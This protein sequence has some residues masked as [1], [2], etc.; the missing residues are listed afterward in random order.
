MAHAQS[1]SHADEHAAWEAAT[2]KPEAPKPTPA[3]IAAAGV[4]LTRREALALLGAAGA[5]TLAGCPTNSNTDTGEN[6]AGQT[7]V[8]RPAE[9]EGPYFVDERLNRADIRVDPADGSIQDGVPLRLKINVQQINSAGCG[10]L[11]GAQVDV[12][13]CNAQ[14]AYSDVAANNTVGRKFL[15]GFQVTDADGAVEFTTIYPGWYSGRTV[16]IHFKVRLFSGNQKT[17]E[18]TSQLYFDE[19]VTNAV[20]AQAPYNTRGTR[21]TTNATD[22]IFHSQLLLALTPE[23]NGYLATFNIGLQMG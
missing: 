13:H 22:G 19:A 6:T 3:K 5:A 10:A 4:I 2:M 20:F 16:H 1:N 11:A 17:Y 18:F 7:C 8:V 15:R 14:G 9:T 21:N 12:W 23:G